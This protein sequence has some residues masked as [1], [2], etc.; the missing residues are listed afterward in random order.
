MIRGL[1]LIAIGYCL[2]AYKEKIK[3]FVGQIFVEMEDDNK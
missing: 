3:E 2:G 1:L